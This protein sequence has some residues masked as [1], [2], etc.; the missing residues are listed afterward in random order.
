LVDQDLGHISVAIGHFYIGFVSTCL[1][2]DAAMA[3]VKLTQSEINHITH[4]VKHSMLID[5]RS[6]DNSVTAANF[7]GDYFSDTL[8]TS[9]AQFRDKFLLLAKIHGNGN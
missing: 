8:H 9:S 7:A 4:A 3:R 6:A 1:P 5:Q 2:R